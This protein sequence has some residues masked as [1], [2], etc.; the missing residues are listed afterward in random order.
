MVASGIPSWYDKMFEFNLRLKL[1]NKEL[2]IGDT[3]RTLSMSDFRDFFFIFE[4]GIGISVF[5]LIIEI[6]L[7]RSQKD[8]SKI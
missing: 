2:E 4:C 3:I 7:H 8:H 5:V 1:K 6:A